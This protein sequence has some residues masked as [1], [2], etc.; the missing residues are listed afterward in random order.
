M[1]HDT[2]KDAH[3]YSMYS[4]TSY[5]ISDGGILILK[6]LLLFY[7]TPYALQLQCM[8]LSILLCNIHSIDYQLWWEFLKWGFEVWTI[9]CWRWRMLQ[10]KKHISISHPYHPNISMGCKTWLRNRILTS[11]LLATDVA[12]SMSMRRN[13]GRGEKRP[14]GYRRQIL[15]IPG[16]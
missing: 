11:P 12:N 13:R 15:R 1:Y 16:H 6:I 3:P 2:K 10:I 5:S 14:V 8:C 4:H 9:G 7:R